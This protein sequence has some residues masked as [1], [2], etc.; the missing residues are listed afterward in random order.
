MLFYFYPFEVSCLFTH[1]PVYLYHNIIYIIYMIFVFKDNTER[2]CSL[3]E[4]LSDIQ[5]QGATKGNKLS[6]A[7][8][9]AFQASGGHPLPQH[10]R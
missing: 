9:S 1:N 10:Q 3:L 4:E 8:F 7:P 6:A 2:C 5:P